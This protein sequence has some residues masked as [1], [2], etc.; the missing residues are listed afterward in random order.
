[1]IREY[2]AGPV[3]IAVLIVSLMTPGCG[4]GAYVA[5]HGPKLPDSQVA[6]FGNPPSARI[7]SVD[8]VSVSDQFLCVEVLPGRRELEVK[9]SWSNRWRDKTLLVVDARAGRGYTVRIHE[10]KPLA[11]AMV[12]GLTES[13]GRTALGALLLPGMLIDGAIRKPPKG[14]PPWPCHL[15]ISDN[16]TRKPVAGAPP[17]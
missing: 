3:A 10:A 1:M 15:W 4:P 16:R 12:D 17:S 2:R 11:V 7:V 5:Y 9:A 13:A 6:R 8:G 14:R